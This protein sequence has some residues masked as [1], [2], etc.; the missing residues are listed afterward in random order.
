MKIPASPPK[1]ETL[2]KDIRQLDRIT[3]IITA[4]IGPAPGGKYRHWDTLRRIKSPGDLTSKEWWMG[5]KFAR[6][7]MM[8]K[9]PLT[10]AQGNPFQYAMPDPVL[11]MLYEIDRDAS[12]QIAT[13]EAITNPHTRDRY[14]QTSLIEEAITSSQL[15]GA[16]TT[17]E[18]A[19][20]MIRSGRKPVNKSETMILNNYHAIQLIREIKSEPLSPDLILEIHREL[21]K[22]TLEPNGHPNFMRVP[23]DG[24]RVYDNDDGKV[25]HDPPP[26]DELEHRMRVMCEFANT[27]Q[28]SAFMHPVIKA[29]I[30][31]FW[32][33]YDHPFIDGNGRT[34]RALFYW[35]MLSQGYWLCEYLTISR[36]LVNAP[37]KYAR[38]F[39]YTETDENDLTYFILYQLSVIQRAIAD[40]WA[41][42][43]RKRDEVSYTES[44]LARKAE[45]NHRQIALIG[46][47]LRHPGYRYSIESHKT[48]HQ[49]TYQTA[50]NDLLDLEQ[51]NILEKFKSGKRFLFV[52][53]ANLQKRL[54]QEEPLEL[55]ST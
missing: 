43:E 39:L 38:S 22:D 7:Q 31:H 34:A 54:Q 44:L 36:I 5:I 30:L 27:D 25:L 26:A 55:P 12:G 51:K 11:E 28:A 21:T 42:L 16:A 8:R 23:N 13:S 1:L 40:L 29:I 14:I 18:V 48:S 45:F 3:Q 10:D 32:L 49:I 50:R 6:T 17:R 2:L 19:K 9:L 47:A 15:E 37:V 53:A 20:G 33:A 35:S 52:P 4:S 41:Y 24:I 46:H